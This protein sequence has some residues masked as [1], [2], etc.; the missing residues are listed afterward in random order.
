MRDIKPVIQLAKERALFRF[1]VSALRMLQDAS[2]SITELTS[3]ANSA[4]EQK[5]FSAK[6]WLATEGG[7]VFLKRLYASYFWLCRA[8]NADHVSRFASG[9]A[10]GI[11]R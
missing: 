6:E 1:S 8:R 4:A 5:Q 9:I 7:T 3:T 2:T 11:Y 10:R